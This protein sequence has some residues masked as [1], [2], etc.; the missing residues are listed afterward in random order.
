VPTG[1]SGAVSVLSGVVDTVVC[2]NL[3]EHYPFAV[4]DAYQS[5]HDLDDEE[6]IR[7]LAIARKNE[8]MEGIPDRDAS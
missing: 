7:Y 6:V 8:L 5:W 1:S 4:A 2:L 3:R